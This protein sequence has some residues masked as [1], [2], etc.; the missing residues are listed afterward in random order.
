MGNRGKY[1]IIALLLALL[2]IVGGCQAPI[3]ELFIAPN[4]TDINYYGINSSI[5]ETMPA[6]LRIVDDVNSNVWGIYE[7]SK[8]TTNNV[9]SDLL[10]SFDCIGAGRTNTIVGVPND[11]DCSIKIFFA[12]DNTYPVQ[13]NNLNFG[14]SDYEIHLMVN[15]TPAVVGTFSIAPDG[16]QTIVKDGVVCTLKAIPR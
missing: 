12:D 8:A 4:N 6:Q 15:D 2:V 5:N 3:A 1:G 9:S 7:I 10:G 16:S 14:S 11:E 13:F